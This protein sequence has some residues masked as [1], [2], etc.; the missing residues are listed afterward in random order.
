M[1]SDHTLSDAF[2]I[3]VR[4]VAESEKIKTVAMLIRGALLMMNFLTR[5]LSISSVVYWQLLAAVD[6]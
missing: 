2:K 1:D 6:D 4:H 3:L 5:G